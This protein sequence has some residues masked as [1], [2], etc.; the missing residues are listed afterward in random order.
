MSEGA[1]RMS[2]GAKLQQARNERRLSLADVTKATKIQS[3]VLDALESDRLH[4]QMSPVY[5]KGF[6]TTYAKFLHLE[7]EPLIAQVLPPQAEAVQA[8]ETEIPSAIHWRLPMQP[9]RL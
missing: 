4:E 2:V 5:L 9:V 8:P 6:L 1:S 7:A 3:W